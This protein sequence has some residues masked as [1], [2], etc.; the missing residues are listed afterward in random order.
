MLRTD[1]SEFKCIFQAQTC[2][3]FI[4][5]IQWC[6]IVQLISFC[7]GSALIFA[8]EMG[9]LDADFRV[10]QAIPPSSLGCQKSLTFF[11]V[12]LVSIDLNQF[13]FFSKLLNYR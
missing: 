3:I 9:P 1:I 12:R 6:A 4:T 13:I 8:D 2:L 5:K 10:F 7:A 11:H